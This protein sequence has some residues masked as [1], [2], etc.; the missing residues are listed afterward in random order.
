MASLHRAVAFEQ[1]HRLARRVGEHLDLDVARTADG[2]FQED[3]RVAER[4][5]G[6]AHRL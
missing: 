3:A 1:V 2:L 5:P 6:L 4:A